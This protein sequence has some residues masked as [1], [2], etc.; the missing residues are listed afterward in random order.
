MPFGLRLF[1][2]LIALA[3][4]FHIHFKLKKLDQQFRLAYELNNKEK[5]G[6]LRQRVSYHQ[7]AMGVMAF[8]LVILFIWLLDSEFLPWFS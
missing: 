4:A 7:G 8:V 6:E 2:F 3:V 5:I 1:W